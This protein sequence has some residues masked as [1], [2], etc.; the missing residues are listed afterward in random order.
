MLTQIT[1]CN[2]SAYECSDLSSKGH[3]AAWLRLFQEFRNAIL[4][5][6]L[7]KQL[8]SISLKV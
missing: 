3:C 5:Y 2:V 4:I 7:V 8:Y 1:S 6:P